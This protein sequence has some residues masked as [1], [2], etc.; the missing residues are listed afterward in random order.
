MKS[1]IAWVAVE[2]RLCE[3]RRGLPKN[4]VGALQ[5]PIFAL[6]SLRRSRSLVVT[7]GRLPA[8]RWSAH[9]STQRLGVQPIFSAIDVI[10]A[11]PIVRRQLLEHQPHAR[12]RT[13]QSTCSAFHR[14][15]LSTSGASGKSV[16]QSE[17]ASSMRLE[18]KARQ[19]ATPRLAHPTRLASLRVLQCV[20]PLAVPAASRGQLFDANHRPACGARWVRSVRHSVEPPVHEA[21]APLA[22]G[23]DGRLLLSRH[24][25]A[26]A[27]CA[28]RARSR[29]PRQ[30][31]R[32]RAPS[33]PPLQRL[34]LLNR[35]LERLTGLPRRFV[36]VMSRT[37]VHPRMDSNC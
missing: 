19:L 17:G 10:A 20:A 16:I 1:I 12:S 8:S 25:R 18:M 29:T 3:I 11:T 6:Q 37:T 33:R 35:Q 24:L 28:H 4:L 15:I 27:A 5:L 34:L 30:S 13:S 21:L 22:D 23:L 36:T 31:L 2:L 14:S 7:P 9:P 32:D 26:R